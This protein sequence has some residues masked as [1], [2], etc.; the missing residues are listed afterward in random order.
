MATSNKTVFTTQPTSSTDNPLTRYVQGGITDVY[1][2]RLGWWDGF[3]AST[4]PD[5]QTFALDAKYNVRPDLL[6]YDLYGKSTLMWLVLWF[7][8]IVDINEEFVTGATI[9]VPSKSRVFSSILVQQTGGNPVTS[10]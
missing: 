3:T 8:A 7:N 1:S 6:A 5:D 4:A 10:T 2:N 9:T